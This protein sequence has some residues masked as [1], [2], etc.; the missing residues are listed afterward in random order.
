[1]TFEATVVQ[2]FIASPSDTGASRDAIERALTRWNS[3]R[4]ESSQVVI[5]PRRYETSA[6]PEL[7]ADGQDVINRQLVSSADIVIAVF[8]NR[9]GSAT[10]RDISGTVEEIKEAD[11]AGKKVHVYFSEADVP[12]QHLGEVAK[13][14]EYKDAFSGLYGTYIDEADLVEQVRHA[15]EADIQGF[16]KPQAIQQ[17]S[18]ANPVAK[19]EVDKHTTYDRKGRP[20]NVN[21]HSIVIENKGLVDAEDFV[22]R[23]AGDKAEDPEV[24]FFDGPP[25]QTL[26]AGASAEYRFEPFASSPPNIR[27]K[28][29]WVEGGEEKMREVVL[30]IF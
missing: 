19:H 30:S 2:V 11:V 12:R 6:V 16:E 29:S 4:A 7:G 20:K 23:F 9:L 1:M 25:L 18:G 13:L 22:A 15:I 3:S 26:Y 5:L 27:V 14:Q 28:M 17:L 21:R 10:Q 8:A 24:M